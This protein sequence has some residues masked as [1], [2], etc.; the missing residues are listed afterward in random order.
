MRAVYNGLLRFDASVSY[1]EDVNTRRSAA[2]CKLDD[3]T[4]VKGLAFEGRASH[5]GHNSFARLLPIA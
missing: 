5:D 4:V 2:E 1:E 3:G